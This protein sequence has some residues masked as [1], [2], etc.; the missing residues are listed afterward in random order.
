VH[1]RLPAVAVTVARVDASTLVVGQGEDGEAMEKRGKR[2]SIYMQ[3]TSIFIYNVKKSNSTGTGTN[4]PFRG[5]SADCR[6]IQ[7]AATT[8]PPPETLSE[9]FAR[10]TPLARPCAPVPCAGPSTGRHAVH[11]SEFESG[12]VDASAMPAL[13]TRHRGS[14]PVEMLM[15]A[16]F[17][18]MSH[19]R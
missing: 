10:E 19:I 4:L 7:P 1:A 3:H 2:S 6:R 15:P 13:T 8:R 16:H 11:H 5:K 18:L 14:A 12:N 17:E 9:E